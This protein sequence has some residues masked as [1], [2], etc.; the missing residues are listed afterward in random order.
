MKE[1][2]RK[3][4]A[5]LMVAMLLLTTTSFST[6]KHFCDGDLVQVSN[7]IKTANCCNSKSAPKKT[8][9]LTYSESDCCTN[10]TELKYVPSFDHNN[11]LK[12]NNSEKIILTSFYCSFTKNLK[13]SINQISVFKNFPPPNIHFDKQILYQSFLI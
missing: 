8:N 7:Y 13:S 6:F 4:S 1:G 12:L 2:L 5:V 10:E 3:I 11:T 9:K